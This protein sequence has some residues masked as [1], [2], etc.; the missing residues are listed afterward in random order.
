MYA[1][2]NEQVLGWMREIL[3]TGTS[4]DGISYLP[5]EGWRD[6]IVHSDKGTRAS[7]GKLPRK[8]GFGF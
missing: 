5:A 7:I 1:V 6:P 8:A 3:K 2:L 4:D